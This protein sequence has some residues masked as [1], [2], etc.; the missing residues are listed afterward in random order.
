MHLLRRSLPGFQI[1][2]ELFYPE[3]FTP[4]FSSSITEI[5]LYPIFDMTDHI[6]FNCS[7]IVA[8]LHIRQPKFGSPCGPA[9]ETVYTGQI[10]GQYTHER[11][12][13]EL[14]LDSIALLEISRM[15]LR[16]Q[17]ALE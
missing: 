16:K 10:F 2:L 8:F 11:H 1:S 3:C 4:L 13:R 6:K 14:F 5:V 12:R 15:R 9:P 17:P 7:F